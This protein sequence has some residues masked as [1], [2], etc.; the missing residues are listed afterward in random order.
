MSRIMR[1]LFSRK[2]IIPV[3]CIGAGIIFGLI[4]LALYQNISF[5]RGAAVSQM[6][7]TGTEGIFAGITISSDL[8]SKDAESIGSFLASGIKKEVLPS[9]VGMMHVPD[10]SGGKE[11]QYVGEW[12][13]GGEKF[14]ILYVRDEKGGGKYMR[15][16]TLKP[17]Q[18]INAASSLDL[19]RELSPSTAQE[20][21]PLGCSDV[22]GEPAGAVTVCEHMV[23][24]PDGRKI[25]GL[26]RSP[27]ILDKGERITLTSVCM[28][29][30]DSS[31]FAAINF[32]I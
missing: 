1:I 23:I 31:A 16:W 9:R 11:S 13:A 10:Q 25:G 15:A 8:P 29:P 20:I 30:K 14:N 3:S 24:T 19:I 18:K 6:P 17:E 22:S 5:L 2:V 32:C 21:A 28:V 26:T 27:L 7:P 12:L 4:S